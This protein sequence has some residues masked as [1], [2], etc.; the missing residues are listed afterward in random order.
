MWKEPILFYTLNATIVV[1]QCTPMSLGKGWFC[2]LTVSTSVTIFD[3]NF[4][5]SITGFGAHKCKFR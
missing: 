4:S 2:E 3:F 5:C 1:S